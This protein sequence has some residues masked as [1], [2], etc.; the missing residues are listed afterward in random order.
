MGKTGQAILT[1]R[2]LHDRSRGVTC[3]VCGLF[4]KDQPWPTRLKA[5]VVPSQKAVL[6]AVV[7]MVGMAGLVVAQITGGERRHV[8]T[9]ND[10]LRVG[11]AIVTRPVGTGLTVVKL[12][13]LNPEVWRTCTRSQYPLSFHNQGLGA[14][15]PEK[16]LSRYT[17][18]VPGWAA[19]IGF[20]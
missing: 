13:K 2:C 16:T 18:S 8:R 17:S 6:T 20:E 14:V 7:E 10:A 3:G 4:G 15:P 1:Q 5:M 9:G 11:H 19:R 12:L